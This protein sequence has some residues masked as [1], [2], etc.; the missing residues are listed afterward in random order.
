MADKI[1]MDFLCNY[2]A[3]SIN[4]QQ[5]FEKNPILNL[6]ILFYLNEITAQDGRNF[7]N[8]VIL[9]IIKSLLY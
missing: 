4:F 6:Q 1:K 8:G 5:F 3:I 2:F 9:F 7:Q